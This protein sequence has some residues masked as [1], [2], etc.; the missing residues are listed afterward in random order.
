[1]PD[2][3]IETIALHRSFGD[4]VAVDG[5]DLSVVRQQF[6]GFLGPN[7]AGKSTTIRMLTGLLQPTSGTIRVLGRDLASDAV[8]IKQRI[9]VV[10]EGLAL[11]ERLTG[12]QLLNFVGRMYGLDRD[13]SASRS[14]ELLEYMD[15]RDAADQLVADYSHG[16]KKKAALAAA[17]IH[18]PEILFL[19]E[20]FEGVDAVAA[21]TLKRMLQR[22]IQHGGTVFLTSHVLEV[23]EKLCTHVGI[24]Q[25][26]K[27]VACGSIEE[28]R[29]G[30]SVPGAEGRQLTLEEI[31]LQV[32]GGASRQEELA[33]L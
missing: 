27:L 6:F 9:G 25:Q 18:S 26:G 24:I 16:M 2:K 31:F 3:V 19:D 11:F 7:G 13:T 12:N 32:V 22:F 21:T 33:W 29:A 14:A 23:V 20:P 8:A 28:L 4:L 1:M 17:V 15:L 30:V 10:P 5:L